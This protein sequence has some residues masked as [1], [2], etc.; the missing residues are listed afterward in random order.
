MAEKKPPETDPEQS[1]R[2]RRVIRDLEAAG[3]LS[4]IDGD[5]AL[6]DLL[7]R[8]SPKDPA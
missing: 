8:R 1:E 7:S 5:K 2:F 3:E 6:D 4:P